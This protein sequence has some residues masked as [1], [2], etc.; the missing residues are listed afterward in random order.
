MPRQYFPLFL[1]LENIGKP[2]SVSLTHTHTHE[3]N[4][5]YSLIALAIICKLGFTNSQLSSAQCG[6]RS[7]REHVSFTTSCKKVSEMQPLLTPAQSCH[8]FRGIGANTMQCWSVLEDGYLGLSHC[9]CANM[10]PPPQVREHPL[11]LVHEPHD[12]STVCSIFFSG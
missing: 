4:T 10:T 7:I 2:Y 8:Q 3:N 9:R 5:Q 6:C 12:P 11:Q 1:G